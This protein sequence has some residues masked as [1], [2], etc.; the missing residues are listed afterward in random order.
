M[1]Y[2]KKSRISVSNKT[3]GRWISGMADQR[4]RARDAMKTE[5]NESRIHSAA[6]AEV[7]DIPPAP[8]HF[9]WTDPEPRDLP[10]EF[11][12]FRIDGLKSQ[13]KAL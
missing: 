11:P 9:G 7:T 6:R 1:V 12:P 4:A 3:N 13:G 8:R 2:K 10:V 5:T